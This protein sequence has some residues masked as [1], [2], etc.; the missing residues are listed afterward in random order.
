MLRRFSDLPSSAEA[1]LEIRLF[2]ELQLERAGYEAVPFPT[3]KARSIF[4]R[5][6]LG[7]EKPHF[8][9]QLAECF[10]PEADP[11]QSRAALRTELWR[12]RLTIARYGL[13]PRHYLNTGIDTIHFRPSGPILVDTE[14]F[15]HATGPESDCA[16]VLAL[17]RAD[18]LEGEYGDWCQF[19]REHYRSRLVDTLESAM[20]RATA[21]GDF[22]TALDLGNRLVSLDPL[23]E[24]IH[25]KLIACHAARGNRSA[26]LKQYARCASL[27]ENELR[28]MPMAETRALAEEI[29]GGTAR[30]FERTGAD[31][32]RT[33]LHLART[34]L[35]EAARKLDHELIARHCGP[36]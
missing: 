29:R 4:A 6:V 24:H 30:L 3:R 35:D 5:L 21:A 25:R 11:S 14:L 28:V 1:P 34:I 26:A 17:Y 27:L 16:T 10:W 7:R 9:D 13:N 36:G 2:G 32:G 15:D 20:E 31:E 23:A 19:Q 33:A 22:G 8:R 18:L 12:I